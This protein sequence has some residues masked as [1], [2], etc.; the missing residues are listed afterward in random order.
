MKVERGK[1]EEE[2]EEEE[3]RTTQPFF[4]KLCKLTNSEYFPPRFINS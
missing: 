2:Q 3:E 1:R 4:P